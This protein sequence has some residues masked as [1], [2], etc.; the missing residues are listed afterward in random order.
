MPQGVQPQNAWYRI[1]HRQSNRALDGNGTFYM[2]SSNRSLHLIDWNDGP[3]Q[4]WRFNRIDDNYYTIINNA[5]GEYLDGGSD[6]TGATFNRR[7]STATAGVM[8]MVHEI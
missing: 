5:T 7:V 2:D 8:S 1:V 3:Y 4:R 6:D